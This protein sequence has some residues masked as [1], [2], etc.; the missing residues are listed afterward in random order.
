MPTLPKMFRH[1]TRNTHIFFISPD[2]KLASTTQNWRLNFRGFPVHYTPI[3][4]AATPQCSWRSLVSLKLFQITASTTLLLHCFCAGHASVAMS[5]RFCGAGDFPRCFCY[6]P[7]TTLK[8]RLPLIYDD[9][10][11][12]VTLL[13]RR[14]LSYAYVALLYSHPEEWGTLAINCNSETS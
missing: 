9:G 2:Y 5:L 4:L 3:L 8:I 7:T 6:D 14:W 1:V 13:R 11:A 10:D 12:A